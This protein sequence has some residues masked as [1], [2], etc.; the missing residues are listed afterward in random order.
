MSYS[1]AMEG[2]GRTSESSVECSSSQRASSYDS[3]CSS[4]H[5]DDSEP[6][7]KASLRHDHFVPPSIGAGTIDKASLKDF[8]TGESQ[9]SRQSTAEPPTSS[10]QQSRKMVDSCTTDVTPGHIIRFA[11][12]KLS[13]QSQRQS[14]HSRPGQPGQEGSMPM[15]QDCSSFVRAQPESAHMD[16]LVQQ[17]AE[18]YNV[19]ACVLTLHC[20]GSFRFYASHG[21]APSVMPPH[22][23]EG[24]QFLCHT[25][26]R[27]L[28]TVIYDAKEHGLAKD[29]ILVT[30]EQQLRFYVCAPLIY[31]RGQYLGSLCIL[32]KRPRCP[33][34][35]EDCRL[36]EEKASEVVNLIKAHDMMAN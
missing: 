27:S 19:E 4:V 6:M 23:R 14:L 21:L 17:L 15:F 7:Q 8:L 28:P 10:T 32:D 29:D 1:T 22:M 5:F 12:D 11:S 36:L 31:T 25:I 34:S 9:L 26:R 35:L 24:F 20:F 2:T 13:N 30:G 3:T 16:A 18:S 33:F